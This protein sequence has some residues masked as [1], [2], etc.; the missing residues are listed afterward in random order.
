M[1]AS[2]G[3]LRLSTVVGPVVLSLDADEIKGAAVERSPERPTLTVPEICGLADVMPERFHLLI[4]LATLLQPAMGRAGALSRGAVDEEQGLIRVWS[5][6]TEMSDRQ[7]ILGPP[8]TAGRPRCGCP[9][10]DGRPAGKA[11]R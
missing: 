10:K 1:P 9:G 4:L 3:V 5:T 2:A 6:L 7:L 11:A 8:R